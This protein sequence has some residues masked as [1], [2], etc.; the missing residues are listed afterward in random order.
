MRTARA[1]PLARVQVPGGGGPEQGA[2]K[3]CRMIYPPDFMPLPSGEAG[4]EQQQTRQTKNWPA[5]Y[6]VEKST[7]PRRALGGPSYTPNT[8][9]AG[10]GVVVLMFPAPASLA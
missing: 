4:R 6:Y 8:D 5:V 10:V 2:S 7:D 9:P 3:D 1:L